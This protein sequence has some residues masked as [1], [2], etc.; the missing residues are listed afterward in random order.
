MNVEGLKKWLKNKDVRI[1]KRILLLLCETGKPMTN[2]KI[3]IALGVRRTST[4]R[5]LKKL[6]VTH[7]VNSEKKDN[8]TMW[9]ITPAGKKEVRKMQKKNLLPKRD[10]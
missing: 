8:V 4:W 1:W 6:R 2:K 10:Y 5:T 3:G 9:S 7:Q